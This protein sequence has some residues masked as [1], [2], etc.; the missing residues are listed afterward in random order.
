LILCSLG[1]GNIPTNKS[2][3]ELFR[4]AAGRGVV[5]QNVT[6][7][8]AGM[9]E[10]GLYA[11]SAK[12]L[13]IGILSGT[14]ITEEAALCKMMVLLGDEDLSEHERADMLQQDLVGEMSLSIYTTRFKQTEQDRLDA[15]NR[16][17]RLSAAD[18]LQGDWK[19]SE[20][21]TAVLRF[22]NASIRTG[23][24]C[25]PM[26]LKVY[27]NLGSSEPLDDGSPNYVGEYRRIPN[28]EPS[29]VSIDVT[30]TARKLLNPGS[31]V[32]FTIALP[33]GCDGSFEWRNAEFCV[34]SGT[35]VDSR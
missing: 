14:D 6:Q 13:E 16:R 18:Y 29:I 11:S 10:L 25:D 31:R 20:I 12:L 9:V 24:E 32:S 26:V 1:A 15:E 3:L 17:Y 30:R 5:I 33:D 23:T 22:R 27:A 35:T 2:F 34:Y 8:T 19:G 7:C 4:D 28:E 21:S